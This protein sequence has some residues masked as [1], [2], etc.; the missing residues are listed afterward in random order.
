MKA[1]ISLSASSLK[2]WSNTRNVPKMEK[3]NLRYVF[4]MAIK[5]QQGIKNH[6]QTRHLARGG[7]LGIVG[8]VGIVHVTPMEAFHLTIMLKIKS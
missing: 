5:S 7:Q 2:K 1:W 4:K 8:F 3:S 6:T